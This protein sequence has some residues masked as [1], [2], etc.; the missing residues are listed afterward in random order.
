MG[1]H[2]QGFGDPVGMRRT[3]GDVDHRQSGGVAESR[4]EQA[5]R[6]LTVVLQAAGVGGVHARRRDA[7][8]G[9]TTADGDDV[10][11]P[12]G[13]LPHPS[14]SSAARRHPKRWKPPL[15]SGPRSSEPSM[16]R[17]STRVRPS[18][19]R[20]ISS[21]ASSTPLSDRLGCQSSSMPWSV[22]SRNREPCSLPSHDRVH[23]PHPPDCSQSR[24]MIHRRRDQ[25]APASC[26]GR[27][28]SGPTR[29]RRGSCC[30]CGGAWR[31]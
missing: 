24:F 3:A 28:G 17:T 18:A 10:P 4:P 2:R 25:D 22:S 5:T 15:P 26:A 16:Q 1:Q 13:D 14:R 21:R 11:R 19:H 27:H 29:R 12:R 20:A 8:P 7:A 9:R 23:P 31:R 6:G 30:P